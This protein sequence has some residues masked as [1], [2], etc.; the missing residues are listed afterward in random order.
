[1]YNDDGLMIMMV[2]VITSDYDGVTMKNNNEKQNSKSS[3]I[4]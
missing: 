4:L 3:C 1:M 2:N